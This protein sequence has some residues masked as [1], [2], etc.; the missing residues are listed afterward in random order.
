MTV[1]KNI[2]IPRFDQ[3]HGIAR[4]ICQHRKYARLTQAELADLAG[5]GKTVVYDIEH[6]KKTVRF[7]TLL[8][9]LAALNISLEFK[10]PLIKLLDQGE[11]EKREN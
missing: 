8:K 6:D 1:K 7:D 4:I 10:S 5:V 9:V 11:N 2:L 3:Q